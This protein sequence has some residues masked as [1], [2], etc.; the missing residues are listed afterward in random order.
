MKLLFQELIR[1]KM[2]FHETI[3]KLTR[4][5]FNVVHTY[6]TNFQLYIKKGVQ[7]VKEETMS[8]LR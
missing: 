8:F 4:F 3:L 5:E 7:E 2:K 6:S 1:T